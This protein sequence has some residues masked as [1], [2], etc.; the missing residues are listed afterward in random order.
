MTES[1]LMELSQLALSNMLGAFTIFISLASG[2][3]LVAYLVGKKLTRSQ[4]WFINTLFLLTMVL[5]SSA[6]HEFINTALTSVIAAKELSNSSGL[7]SEQ[8]WWAVPITYLIDFFIIAGCLKFMW[9][10]RRDDQNLATR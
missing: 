2:Y 10:V 1:E 9:D 6:I 4:Y 7:I 3:L 8:S 5:I